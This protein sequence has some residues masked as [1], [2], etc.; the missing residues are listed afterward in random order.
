M[1][2]LFQPTQ[3]QIKSSNLY[4]YEDYLNRNY[5]KKFKNY[6]QLWNWSVNNPGDFWKSITEFYQ[7]PL[8]KNKNSKLFKKNAQFWKNNF[9]FN[10][11]TNYFQ[12]IEK[13]KS[14]SLA[15]HLI[16]ENNYEEKISYKELNLKV[17]AL[18]SYY[19]SL[20][21]KKGDVVVGY[22]PNIADT[23]IAFLASAKIGAVWSSCSSDFG[24]K[25]VIDRFSQLKPKLLIIADHYFYN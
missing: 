8:T 13:N 23:I 12:L 7:V 1:T 6:S 15:I 20:G 21:I 5:K 16:G 2:K 24:T 22:L 9:F 11:Q 10:F 14:T 19:K 3:N 18:S 17:N 4:F 25:A